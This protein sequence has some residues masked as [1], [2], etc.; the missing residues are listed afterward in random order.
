MITKSLGGVCDSR[1][2][3]FSVLYAEAL[4]QPPTSPPHSM[5]T[6]AS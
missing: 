2:A 4:P 3:V 5:D 6:P 1:Y